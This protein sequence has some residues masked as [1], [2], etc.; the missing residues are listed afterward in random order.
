MT[1]PYTIFINMVKDIIKIKQWWILQQ[2]PFSHFIQWPQSVLQAHT[3]IKLQFLPQRSRESKQ[4]TTLVQEKL[5]INST[6]CANVNWKK[7]FS[8]IRWRKASNNK[9]EAERRFMQY[10]FNLRG[11]KSQNKATE[12]LFV[13]KILEKG[14]KKY[15]WKLGFLVFATTCSEESMKAFRRF[16]L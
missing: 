12:L 16:I 1:I 4:A 5:L 6:L 8:L 7:K 11:V 10:I 14:K 3:T 13:H 15:Y 9:S 2:S